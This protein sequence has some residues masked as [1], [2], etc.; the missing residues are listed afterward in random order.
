[1]YVLL[2]SKYR[3]GSVSY[4]PVDL[5][6]TDSEFIVIFFSINLIYPLIVRSHCYLL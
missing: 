3:T 1:M 6:A 5:K 4:A 2:K